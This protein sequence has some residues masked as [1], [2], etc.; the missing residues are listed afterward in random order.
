MFPLII[1]FT[2]F[3]LDHLQY[4]GMQIL[5]PV[6]SPDKGKFILREQII[7]FKIKIIYLLPFHHFQFKP[8]N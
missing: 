6:W 5:C 4:F 1:P 8:V 3:Y 2:H 7:F